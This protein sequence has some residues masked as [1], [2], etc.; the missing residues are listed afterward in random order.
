MNYLREA[1]S[2]S[3]SFRLTASILCCFTSTPPFGTA[4]CSTFR[5]SS[6]LSPVRA[7]LL[8]QD[9]VAS[10]WVTVCG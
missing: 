4:C 1:Q 5:G 10:I 8:G 7:V 9:Q 2:Q 6:R 3:D